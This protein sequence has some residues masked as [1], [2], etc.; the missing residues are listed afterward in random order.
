VAEGLARHFDIE[1]LEDPPP[2]TIFG[3]LVE[4]IIESL[5]E[6]FVEASGVKLIFNHGLIAG[7]CFHRGRE[8][9]QNTS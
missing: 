8:L 4:R 5:V 1:H 7:E 6:R 9:I 2:N 3:I